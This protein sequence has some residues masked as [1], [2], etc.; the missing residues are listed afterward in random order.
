MAAYRATKQRLRAT[1]LQ[2][3]H[4]ALE[5]DAGSWRVTS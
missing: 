1:E 5:A 3:L 2:T 4:K